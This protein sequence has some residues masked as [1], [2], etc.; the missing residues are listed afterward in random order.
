MKRIGK[1]LLIIIILLAYI[2]VVCFGVLLVIRDTESGALQTTDCSVLEQAFVKQYEG[3][4]QMVD[5]TVEW[6]E[7]EMQQERL[8]ADY[9][10]NMLDEMSMEQKLAQMMILTNENDIHATNLQTYQPAG[11]IFFQVDFSGKTMEQVG[12][13]IQTLQSYMN[14]PLFVGVDEEGGEVSRLKNL[15]E[16]DVPNFAS[17]RVLTEQGQEAIIEDTRIK[18]QYLKDMGLNLNFAPVADVVD[19]K[20]SYMYQRSSSGDAQ[21]AAVYVTT[22]LEVMQEE[23][24]MACVKHFPGYGNNVNTHDGLAH[25]NRTVEEYKE[26]DLIPFSASIEAGVD[27]VMVSHIIMESVDENHPASLSLTVHNILRK[28]MGFGGVIIADDLNMQA[29]LKSMT[30]QEATAEALVAGNDM[31]FSA[32]FA[33]SM[34]G[35]MNAVNQGKLTEEQVD[36]SVERVLR[37]KIKNGLIALEQSE[38]I[39]E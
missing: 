15:A 13:R 24:V 11:V 1:V 7:Q 9:V 19:Q 33:A 18:M 17:A 6:C 37:M 12:A 26:K 28:D 25:D 31:I 10:T 3:F 29:I 38:S 35:A 32:D 34:R 2:G 5:T 36:A 8:I 22:V 4:Q 23:Q 27:M 21:V 30:I 39:Q 20:S 14:I 16:A